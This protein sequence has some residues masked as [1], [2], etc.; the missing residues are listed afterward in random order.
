MRRGR[1]YLGRVIKTGRLDDAMLIQA[2]QD[3]ATVRSGSYSW[4]FS[5][6]RTF[7][8][9]PEFVYAKLA[10]FEPVG[11]VMVLEG[12]EEVPAPEANLL[13]T[14]SPFVYIPDQAAI[15]ALHI[16]N[17]I[18]QQTF[19]RRFS[20]IIEETFE[21]FFVTCDIEPISD[22]QSFVARLRQ[23]DRIDSITATVVPPNPLFGPAWRQVVDYLRR[24]NASELKVAESAGRGGLES[25]VSEVA[26]A[27][28]EGG[29]EA[30]ADRP[31]LDIVDAAVLM[32]ADGYGKAKVQGQVARQEV[33]VRT[34]ET[35]QSFV[36]DPDPEPPALY[37]EAVSHLND[38]VRQRGLQHDE[39]A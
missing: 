22:L 23:F 3:P 5:N 28:S 18:E 2:L 29:A 35:V 20:Q 1:Y 26:T 10:K 7:G 6:F 38:I 39:D 37:D 19:R 9:P 31:P 33:L 21:R 14:S 8:D 24:R 13:V 11:E 16:W 32:A 12:G 36:F 15:A 4:T 27:V 34:T 17:Q 25:R 30:I